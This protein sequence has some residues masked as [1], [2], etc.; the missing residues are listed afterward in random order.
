MNQDKDSMVAL[1]REILQDDYT[2]LSVRL[3][4]LTESFDESE[5]LCRLTCHLS[6]VD[7]SDLTVESE[8]V[9]VIDALFTGLRDRLADDYPSL[10]SIRFSQLNIKG[11][12]AK[13]DG[14][15][16]TTQ[17]EAEATVGILNSEGA[18][19]IFQATAPS[20][21]RAGMQ[22]TVRA[23]QYFVNSE[24]TFVRLHEILQ[25]YREEGRTD[26]VEKYTELMSRVVRNTSYSEVVERIKKSL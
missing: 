12:I 11:L 2:E 24:R 5:P 10:R 16:E 3:Y 8:G 9:G 6:N 13:E 17:A 1:M 22:A 7:G 21:S 23:A 26:L 25:H 14:T 19:F 15:A 4:T 18:E 20:V